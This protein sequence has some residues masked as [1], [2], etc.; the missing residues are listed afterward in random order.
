MT[1]LRQIVLGGLAAL[2]LGGAASSALAEESGTFQNR[3]NG[4]TIGLPLGALP[5]AGIYSGLETVYLGMVGGP[6]GIGNQGTLGGTRLALPAIAQAVPVLFVPGWNFL[7]ASYSFSVVQAFYMGFVGQNVGTL[8]TPTTGFP[9]GG[10]LVSP[11]TVLANTTWN[12]INLSWN[13]GNGWFV[14]AGFN[15]M[16]PDGSRWA[17]TPNPDY[18]TLE[19][20]FAV[21]YLANNWVL[22][23]NFFYDINT[24]S[25]GPCCIGA[26][27]GSVT[28]GNALYG[29]FTAV[30]KFGKWEI[31]P[32]AYFEAQTT[33]DTGARCAVA[34]V[35]TGLC[36]TNASTFDLG[37]L[38]GYDFGPVDVQVWFTQSVSH[39]NFIDSSIFWTRLGFK[40]WGPDAPKPL[41]AKN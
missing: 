1:R 18:W 32:V 24:V 27:I 13:V 17:G 28:S 10:G 15:F 5:P 7:G 37:A 41:V 20:T 34:G 6:G 19:P 31:G 2:A 14:S 16:A 12:P 9:G 38:V 11:F 8:N 39:Q 25:N 30:Y 40:L 35:A 21:S 4:A 22:S 29:D 3:L 36:V 23:A 33:A 26:G